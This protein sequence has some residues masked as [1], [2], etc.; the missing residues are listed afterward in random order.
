MDVSSNCDKCVKQNVC[1]ALREIRFTIQKIHEESTIFSR[2]GNSAN[3]N[4]MLADTSQTLAY[5]CT[6]YTPQKEDYI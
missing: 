4:N 6:E 1:F 3:Y 2:T 5:L